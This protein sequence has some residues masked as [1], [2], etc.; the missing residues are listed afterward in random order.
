[1]LVAISSI[2]AAR[3]VARAE[4]TSGTTNR[5]DVLVLDQSSR[6]WAER[7]EGQ[8]SDL[9]VRARV[10]VLPSQ[11]FQSAEE[12]KQLARDAGAKV[13][14]WMTNDA[15]GAAVGAGANVQLNIW[16]SGSDD[17]YTRPIAR[18]HARFS[19]ADRS[20]SLE[21]AALGVRS[22]VRSLLLDPSLPPAVSGGGS[23]QSQPSSSSPSASAPLGAE[24]ESPET[25]SARS[26]PDPSSELDV[27]SPAEEGSAKNLMPRE[28]GVET[29]AGLQWHEGAAIGATAL[30]AGVRAFWS[31]WGFAAIGQYGLPAQA[32][33][34]PAAFDWQRHALIGELEYVAWRRSPWRASL[35][36]RA[37]VASVRRSRATAPDTSLSPSGPARH[38]FVVAGAGAI[39]ECAVSSTASLYARTALNVETGTPR[40]AVTSTSG[41]RQWSDAAWPVQ[42]SLELGANWLW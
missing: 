26:R 37:G 33:V 13:T 32:R 4:A 11:S 36:A 24:L 28:L 18:V 41:E 5:V 39:L 27:S 3:G 7:V 40:F 30:H 2:L 21:L 8:L 15:G 1:M 31:D 29:G 17:V 14:V 20:A 42:P 19:A 38:E 16:F 22:A 10:R 25:S 35:L 9:P 12:L 23:E 6:D 34:G